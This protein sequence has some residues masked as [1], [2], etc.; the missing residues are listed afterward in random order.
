MKK[1]KKYKIIILTVTAPQTVLTTL[2]YFQWKKDFCES[3][4]GWIQYNRGVAWFDV[5]TIFLQKWHKISWVIDP[6]EIAVLEERLVRSGWRRRSGTFSCGRQARTRALQP[7]HHHHHHH[8][9]LQVHHHHCTWYATTI[10]NWRKGVRG[11]KSYCKPTTALYQFSFLK[12]TFCSEFEEKT[13][14]IISANW[15]KIAGTAN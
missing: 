10:T 9:L 4:S 14:F 6:A 5:R 11:R 12:V 1:D 2:K 7:H 13:A 15:S 8:H 3:F